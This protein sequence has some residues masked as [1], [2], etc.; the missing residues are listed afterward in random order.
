[1]LDY[2]RQSYTGL[3]YPTKKYYPTWLLDEDD[4]AV[5]AG[6]RAATGALGEAP[7]V[8]KWGFSTNGIATCGMFGVPTI[9]FGP[10]DEAYAHGPEDQ[11][12]VEHLTKAAQFYAAFPAAFLAS[13]RRERR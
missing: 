11:C 2:A 3:T 10:G 9:G 1:V 8:G 7:R 12:P 6:V 4:P 5:T 13:A